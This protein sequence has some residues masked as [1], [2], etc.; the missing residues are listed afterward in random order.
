LF[1]RFKD[2]LIFL[3]SLIDLLLFALSEGPKSEV[4]ELCDVKVAQLGDTAH[5]SE[6]HRRPLLECSN[7]IHQSSLKRTVSDLDDS[8]SV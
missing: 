4:V 8:V 6:D 2:P 5:L 1:I 7:L 3:G